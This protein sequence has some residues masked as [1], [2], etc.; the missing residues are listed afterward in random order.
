VKRNQPLLAIA[1][2]EVADALSLPACIELVEAAMADHARGRTLASELLHL[3]AGAGEVHVK[4]SGLDASA[5]GGGGR[6]VAVKTGA[7]FYDRPARLGLPSIVGLIQLFDGTTGQPLAVMESA[8]VT[9]LRTAAATAVAVRHLALDGADTLLLCGT[10]AQAATHLE[11][12]AAVHTLRRVLV[13]SRDP[14]RAQTF[15][16]RASGPIEV[17][18]EAVDTPTAGAARSQ[19]VVTLTPSTRPLLRAGDL[20]PGT[21]V[22][23]V[24]SD[25]PAKQELDVALLSAA[26]VV[27]DVT[28][29]CAR[30]GELH[31]ALDAGVMTSADVRA[32]L[33]QVVAGSCPG[34]QDDD[35][36]VVFDS[37]GTAVQDTAAAA[38][39]YTTVRDRGSGQL[40]DLWA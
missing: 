29:Q 2:T 24:G 18:I 6:F 26:A 28:E 11:A 36:I 13:W 35:E 22:A 3:D 25:A 40:V 21:L 16:H 8:L 20:Q 34:R 14:E 1:E 37:T 12:V 19:L 23:A 38:H 4:A 7:C 10:G 39:V 17:D 30:V 15:A 32:E 27:T 31:H 5:G 9:R 33:G